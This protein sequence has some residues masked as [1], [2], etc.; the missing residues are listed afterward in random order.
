M[1]VL[2]TGGGTAGHINPALAIAEI[3]RRNA[4]GSEIAFVGIR[5]G[6]EEDLVPREGYPLYY[7]RSKGIRRSVTPGAILSN[8]GALWLAAT[9][10]YSRA[11][12]DIIRNFQPDIA[13]GTGGYACWPIMAAAARMGIPTALHESN[14]LP[15]LAVR[16]LQGRVDRIWIN[17]EGTAKQL[18]SQRNVR[19]VGNPLRGGFGGIPKEE[20]KAKLGL[21]PGE[22]L[23]L[24]FGGSLGAENLNRAVLD[25]M[26]ALAPKHPEVRFLLASGKRDF[27]DC[28][29]LFRNAGLDGQKN[30]V[31]TDYI[32]DMPLRMSAADLVV[33][34]AG[35]MTLSE[36]GR[37]ALPAVLVPSPNVTDDHQLINANTVADAGA[38]LVAEE[39]TFGEGTLTA[40]V[41]ALLA[42]GE[43]LRAMGQAA[44]RFTD[45]D[46]DRLI[47]EDIA[48][49][50]GGK[51]QKQD[52]G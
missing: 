43:R 33:S 46:T 17:F 2:L 18:K 14:A 37:M 29:G 11:T 28:G 25:M 8:I 34:R 44:K 24:C 4:P 7:V 6:K 12:C 5:G 40:A 31:L 30:C 1:K 50:T 15:G 19:R 51:Q 47:W 52:R 48:A 42:D 35:A 38:A 32:Y 45:A 16:K 26:A 20:A 27:A 21:A 22:R 36:L 23:V 13:I 39:K 10:P 41:E 49:L 3:I 9:S